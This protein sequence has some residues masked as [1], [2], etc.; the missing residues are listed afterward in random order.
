MI[1]TIIILLLLFLL[2]ALYFY[3]AETKNAVDL[4]GKTVLDASKKIGNSIIDGALSMPEK[5]KEKFSNNSS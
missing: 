5:I 3:P 1:K 4:T 2:F